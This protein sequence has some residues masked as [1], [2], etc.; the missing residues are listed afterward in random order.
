MSIALKTQSNQPE[1][2][3]FSAKN[4]E[5]ARPNPPRF[6]V[7]ITLLAFFF[8]YVPL[9]VV[10]V[11]SF[12]NDQPG[13]G[14]LTLKWYVQAFE[15]DLLR[16]S[17]WMSLWVGLG[18]TLGATVLGTGAAL[19][20][21]R[22]RFR[23]RN[24]FDA[25]NLIPLVMPEIVMGL[26]LLIWFV[27]LKISLGMLSMTLAHITFCL[28]FVIITVRARLADYDDSV[29]E[30]ARDLGATPWQTFWKVTLPLIWP[31]ILSGGLMAF[32]LSFDDFLIAYFT[33]GVGNDTLPVKLYAMIKYGVSPTI[34]AMS[35]LLVVATI[36]LVV[37][38]MKRRST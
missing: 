13:E 31:G 37:L 27:F 11:L 36:V 23:G 1:S 5:R 24:L 32:T 33:S 16:E 19:A 28:S 18:S 26:S 30:A 14:V 2:S 38:G 17:L 8:L 6:A 35:T 12:L 10:A 21:E 20:L 29:E 9:I 34:N 15:N 4:Q 25:L 22:T 7:G 3:G